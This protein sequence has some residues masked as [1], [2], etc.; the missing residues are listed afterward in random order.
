MQKFIYGILF[1]AIAIAVQSQS[2]WTVVRQFPEG[3]RNEK[4]IEFLP[5][6]YASVQLDF[7]ALVADLS[8]A[9]ME[10]STAGNEMV[11]T[12]PT[13]EGKLMPFVVQ[14][15][16][17]MEAEISARYPSIK[18]FKAWT[19]DKKYVA[20]FDNGPFG[21][22]ASIR[23]EGREI[24]IDPFYKE[25]NSYYIV[26]NISDNTEPRDLMPGCGT[27]HAGEAVRKNTGVSARAE[28]LNLH[29]YRLALACTGEWGKNTRNR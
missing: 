7:N 27:D 18:S 9:P 11:V 15:S 6:K 25:N 10:K 4:A 8:H 20:R 13:P 28:S 29:V 17:V 22:H 16:P 14:Q 23:G 24:Y 3:I 26:Y 21:F 12:L 19:K 5:T 2:R 1:C